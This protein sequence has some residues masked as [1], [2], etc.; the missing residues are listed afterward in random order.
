MSAKITGAVPQLPSMDLDAARKFYQEKLLFT[1]AGDYPG[2][3]IM[4]KDS[5]ELHLW[6]CDDRNIAEHSGCY[7]YVD[8]VDALYRQ[9]KHLPCVVC[10]PE[11]GPRGVREFSLLDDSGNLLIF[12]QKT[13]AG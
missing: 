13:I 8:N 12:G 10:R 5:V 6:K 7:L 2:L 9:Y 3:L 4:T 11:D 1:F